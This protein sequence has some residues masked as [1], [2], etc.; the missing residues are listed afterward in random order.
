[1]DPVPQKRC[2]LYLV[3][4]TAGAAEMV[5][6]LPSAVLEERQSNG[7]GT[8]GQCQVSAS[9]EQHHPCMLLSAPPGLAHTSWSSDAAA[10]LPPQFNLP[11]GSCL[12]AKSPGK[13][14]R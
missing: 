11:N 9:P 12:Y 4:M 3:A 2:C 8:P 13:K 1:M 5:T 6:E 14:K 7:T 10:F